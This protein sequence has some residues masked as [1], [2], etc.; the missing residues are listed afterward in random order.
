LDESKF[1]LKDTSFVID[2]FDS[3]L[4]EKK[5]KI[6][7]VLKGLNMASQIIA[8]TGSLM[9]ECHKNFIHN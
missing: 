9:Q 6:G 2:E 5:Y 8:F 1:P 3:I 7:D 4:F